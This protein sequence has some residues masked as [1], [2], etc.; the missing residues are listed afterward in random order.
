MPR[1]NHQKITINYAKEKI[2]YWENVISVLEKC[3]P[4]STDSLSMKIFKLYAN[5]QNVSDI[6]TILKKDGTINQN[7]QKPY[8]STE[9]TSFIK[10]NTIEDKDIESFVKDLQKMNLKAARRYM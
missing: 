7:T 8:T 1:N 9:I 10:T 3:T 4:S 2:Q 5:L 6:A